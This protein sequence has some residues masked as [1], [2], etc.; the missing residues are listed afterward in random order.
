MMVCKIL[1]FQDHHACYHSVQNIKITINR[2]IICPS[3]H[4]CVCVYVCV[5]VCETWSVTLREE[6]RLRV[7]R[8]RVGRKT[9]GHVSEDVRGDWRKLHRDELHD[10]YCSPD[11]IWVTRSRMMR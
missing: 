5:C 6:H 2:T 3:F 8:N 11:I 1:G 9:F 4:V 7:F 10:L